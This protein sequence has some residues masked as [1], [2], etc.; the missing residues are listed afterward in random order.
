MDGP[1]PARSHDALVF[2]VLDSEIR[3]AILDAL[4]DRTVEPGP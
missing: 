1:L 4:Y 2:S 3:L